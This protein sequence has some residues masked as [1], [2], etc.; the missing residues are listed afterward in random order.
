MEN[1]KKLQITTLMTIVNIFLIYLFS[2]IALN[3]TISFYQFFAVLISII[4]SIVLFVVLLYPYRKF[5]KDAKD[6][7]E[8]KKSKNIEGIFLILAIIFGFMNFSSYSLILFI[9]ANLVG[10]YRTFSLF[11]LD[12][13]ELKGFILLSVYYI[14]L[15]LFFVSCLFTQSL[16]FI[17]LF[18]AGISSFLRIYS[19]FN[20][21]FKLKTNFN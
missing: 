9:T 18:F 6:I 7:K 2:L 13:I 5:I 4:I 19:D 20:K 12:K 14:S 15:I 17:P 8:E 21:T 16:N 10:Y 11:E 1:Q 3:G